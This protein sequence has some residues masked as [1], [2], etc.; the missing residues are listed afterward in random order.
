MARTRKIEPFILVV[1]DRDHGTF[2][3]EGPMTDDTRWNDAVCVAQKTGRQINCHTAGPGTREQV[4]VRVAKE[5]KLE[6][7]QSGSIV[8][9]W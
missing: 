9:V 1:T 8:S 3:I 7:V 6:Q 2:S 5:L 4:A